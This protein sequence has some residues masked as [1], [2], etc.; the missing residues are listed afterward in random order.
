MKMIARNRSV[1]LN[2]ASVM[3]SRTSLC[4]ERLASRNATTTMAR[5]IASDSPYSTAGLAARNPRQYV[6]SA[7]ISVVIPVR[8][9]TWK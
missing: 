9:R 7:A 2:S 8:G 3:V 4:S 6:A 1:S 5:P